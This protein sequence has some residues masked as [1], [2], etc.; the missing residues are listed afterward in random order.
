[1]VPFSWV[2]GH[3]ILFTGEMLEIWVLTFTLQII[4]VQLLLFV[5]AILR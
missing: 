5:W 3:R 1:M 2:F 4:T